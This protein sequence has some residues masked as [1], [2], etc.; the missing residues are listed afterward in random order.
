LLLGGNLAKGA[1]LGHQGWE[2][3]PRRYGREPAFIVVVPA[4]ERAGEP[5]EAPS[6]IGFDQRC[7]AVQTRVLKHPNLAVFPPHDDHRYPGD[8][9]GLVVAGVGQL[10]GVADTDGVLAEEPVEFA[11]EALRVGVRRGVALQRP[12]GEVG[13][14][15]VDLFEEPGNHLCPVYGHGPEAPSSE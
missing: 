6:V 15:G 8:F 5:F 11:G 14:L 7:A 3:A 12:S 4:V 10:C 9:G 1:P 2:A 13:K